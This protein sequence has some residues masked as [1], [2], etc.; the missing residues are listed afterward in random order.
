MAFGFF[1][2][3]EV[4]SPAQMALRQRIALQMLANAK[5]SGYPKNLGEGLTAIGDAIGERGQIATLEAQM[6]AYED[7]KAAEKRASDIE[8]PTPG[9]RADAE[10]TVSPDRPAVAVA[11][12]EPVVRDVTPPPPPVVVPPPPP[13]AQTLQPPPTQPTIA[14]DLTGRVDP[15]V[16]RRAPG[17]FPGPD[18]Q[19]A[20]IPASMVPQLGQSP[21]VSGVIGRPQTQMIV[22]AIRA[23]AAYQP[24]DVGL[25][26]PSQ[27]A[28]TPP[29][30]QAGPRSDMAGPM[31]DPQS[32]QL[33]QLMGRGAPG[34][35]PSPYAPTAS[36]GSPGGT[37]SDADP[38]AQTR[39]G[40]YAALLNQQGPAGAVPPANPTMPAASPPP[41]SPPSDTSSLGSPLEAS[42]NRPI[43]TDMRPA[44]AE[45]VPAPGAQL[46]QNGAYG[47]PNLGPLA[48]PQPP[49][50]P[51]NQMPPSVPP[52][53]TPAVPIPPAPEE[54]RAAIPPSAAKPLPEPAVPPRVLPSAQ[55]L[56]ME[57][58]ARDTEDADMKSY[59]GDKAAKFEAD[60]AAQDTRN[61]DKWKADHQAWEA[62]RARLHEY[63][64]NTPVREQAI[65]K[66]ED[67]A[68]ARERAQKIEAQQ[69]GI[70]TATW[71][72][73]LKTGKEQ[74]AGIPA[75]TQSIKRARDLVENNK[76]FFGTFADTNTTISKV[77]SAAGFPLDPKAS[78]TEQFKQAMGGILAQ[79]RKSIVGPGAQ[80]DNEMRVLQSVTGTDAKLTPDTIKAALNSAEKLNLMMALQH[81]KEVRQ[82]AGEDDPN[83]KA[84]VYRA[85]GVP[86]MADLV[87]QASVNKLFKFSS[88]PQV[89]KDF[90]D[91]YHT[92]GLSLQVLR[93][94]KPQ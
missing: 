10:P 4:G 12:E 20:S 14:T 84:A 46:A 67:E 19:Q 48:R 18:T 59:Y 66:G 31:T 13:V 63:Y 30:P 49:L 71:L 90:D 83:R 42:Q 39:A 45:P 44:P 43:M 40:I 69:G 24:N 60:R 80:S 50:P 75:A 21:P 26:P 7:V 3:E 34:G 76:M 93:F 29:Q 47:G 78:G 88:D 52:S 73:N 64:L 16:E 51:G 56:E 85:Y 81:Q 32:D 65:K 1:S 91:T 86:N 62:D 92:P 23:R 79:A 5:R 35:P 74:T 25:P 2:P 70:P 72:E 28:N 11:D 87:P 61:M 68:Q 53:G 54:P 55:Q 22:D 27:I 9:K 77:M 94:R 41:T 58:K 82:F 57:R 8:T 89:H 6:K 38:V 17:S 37:L 15:N 33:A 36:L